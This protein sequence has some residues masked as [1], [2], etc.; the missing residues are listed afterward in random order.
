MDGERTR[1]ARSDVLGQRQIQHANQRRSH[2]IIVDNLKHD[3]AKGIEAT[4]RKSE[5]TWISRDSQ[6]S[7]GAGALPTGTG[8]GSYARSMSMGNENLSD[9]QRVSSSHV[10]NGSEHALFVP[11]GRQRLAGDLG[12]EPVLLADAQLD[13]RVR[14]AV[15]IC[16][17][18]QSENNARARA[19][20]P[21]EAGSPR[22]PTT[23]TS[24]VPS[25]R[26]DW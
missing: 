10:N 5:R 24:R 11:G 22:A 1:S 19:H 18:T 17:T 8:T 26:T 23:R 16:R 6:W 20:C 2:Q 9:R 12:L 3:D 15:P 25:P 21:P 7:A 4:E 13:E 14:L